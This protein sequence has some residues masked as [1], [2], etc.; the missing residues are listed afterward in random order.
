MSR[1]KKA[2]GGHSSPPGGGTRNAAAADPQ[3]LA[4]YRSALSGY[5]L[6]LSLRGLTELSL[7]ALQQLPQLVTAIDAS[8]N[9]IV[10]LPQGFSGLRWACGGAGSGSLKDASCFCSIHNHKFRRLERV[11]PVTPMGLQYM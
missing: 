8:L 4:L 3:T 1:G 2:S 6:D 11:N 7:P 9:K 10:A 5:A